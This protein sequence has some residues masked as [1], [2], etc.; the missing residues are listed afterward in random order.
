MLP[1]QKTGQAQSI[2]RYGVPLHNPFLPSC[3]IFTLLTI[4]QEA[5]NRHSRTVVRT[6][7]Q[8]PRPTTLNRTTNRHMSAKMVRP[9]LMILRPSTQSIKKCLLHFLTFSTT[10][11]GPLAKGWSSRGNLERGMGGIL[12]LEDR[13]ALASRL[14]SAN[15]AAH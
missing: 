9:P 13:P 4:L 11:F 6:Q 14:T 1:L 3:F 2:L 12:S 5:V 8:L 15:A 10:P 7:T